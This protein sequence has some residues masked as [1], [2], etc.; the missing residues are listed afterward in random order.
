MRQSRWLVASSLGAI[1]VSLLAGC[2]SSC[3]ATPPR[4]EACY[5]PATGPLKPAVVTPGASDAHLTASGSM[6]DAAVP[7]A[8]VGAATSVWRTLPC[9]GQLTTS[10]VRLVGGIPIAF[11]DDAG[12][13]CCYTGVDFGV[14]GSRCLGVDAFYRFS[15]LQVDRLGVGEDGGTTHRAGVKAT[16]ERS[17]PGTAL[18]GWAGAGPEVIWTEGYLEDDLGWGGY[19]EAGVGWRLS[20]R[21]RLRAGVGVHGDRTSLTRE[22]AQEDGESRWLITVVP[23]FGVEFDF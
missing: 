5:G 2:A 21:W 7:V 12:K 23:Q 18:Y 14:T 13:A 4:S 8:R 11:G 15:G 3:P 19:A 9:E 1:A 17:L 20:S 10:H 6:A 22:R 16:I